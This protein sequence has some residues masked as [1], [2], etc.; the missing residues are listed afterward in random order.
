MLNFP[1]HFFKLSLPFLSPCLFGNLFPR[2]V[3]PM[4]LKLELL[5]YLPAF[6]MKCIPQ[7]NDFIPFAE[8]AL[9]FVHRQNSKGINSSF[10][11]K[12]HE[13]TLNWLIYRHSKKLLFVKELRKLL[14]MKVPQQLLLMKAPQQLL[15][16]KAPQ[17]LLLMKVPQQLLLM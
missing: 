8:V 5:V 9:K 14:L 16:M 12:S 7:Q 1:V 15:L 11:Y 3:C 2:H 6:L 10:T 4:A 17:L 13:G